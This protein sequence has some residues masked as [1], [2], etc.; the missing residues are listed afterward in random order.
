MEIFSYLPL[1]RTRIDST[2]SLSLFSIETGSP[3][4]KKKYSVKN[5]RNITGLWK[6]WPRVKSES[7]IFLH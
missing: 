1:S 6:N 5:E 4:N 7:A 2:A 3:S